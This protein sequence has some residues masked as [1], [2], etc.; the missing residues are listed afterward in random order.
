MNVS[1]LIIFLEHVM[2]ENGDI[3]VKAVPPYSE[4]F[5]DIIH[6]RV[7]YEGFDAI[8]RLS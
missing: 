5:K 1:E 6:P 7:I 2:L 8:V 3:P 4:E